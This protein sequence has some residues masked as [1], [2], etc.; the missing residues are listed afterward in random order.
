MKMLIAEDDFTCRIVLQEML[1]EFGTTHVA[2]NGN[3]AIE[4]VHVA[5]DKGEPYDLI[6]LDI[7]M[8]ELDGQEALNQIR[9]L[10][11]EHGI[12][13]TNGAKILM[14]TALDDIKNVSNAYNKL[15]DGYLAK[16]YNRQQLIDTL[17]GMG[18]IE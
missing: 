18:L 12:L 3:E 5:R 2:V 15:C 1:S 9:N 7:M 4:A 11:E 16:P 6:C 13:S 8:P 14:S 17:R 10:E